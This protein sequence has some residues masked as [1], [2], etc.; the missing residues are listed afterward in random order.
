MLESNNT[1]R[2]H[3]CVAP[4]ERDRTADTLATAAVVHPAERDQPVPAAS[5]AG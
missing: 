5:A 3:F 1:E 2:L 4:V